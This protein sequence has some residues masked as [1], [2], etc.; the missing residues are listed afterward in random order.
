MKR[1]TVS[2]SLIL[3]LLLSTLPG[4]SLSQ[5]RGPQ[6]AA[7]LQRRAQEQRLKNQEQQKASRKITDEYSDEAYQEA[8]GAT[9]EQWKAIKPRLEKIKRLPSMPGINVSIYSFSG[10]SSFTQTSG[11]GGGGSYS[12]GAGGSGGAGGYSAGSG[13]GGGGMS[14]SSQ[15]SGTAATSGASGSQGGSSTGG[16]GGG[17]AGGYG[18]GSVGGGGGFSGGSP[19]PVKKKVGDVNLG[20]QWRRPSL[21]KGVDKLSESEKTC[22]QLLDALEAKNPNP[23][24]VRRQVEALRKLREQRQAEQRQARQQLREVVTP[25]Q[26]AKLILMGYLD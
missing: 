13:G 15:S 2:L 1:T 21:D 22:E 11:G 26:E 23:D 7:E 18:Q 20:W 12:A 8:L 5:T 25:E 4:R 14:S 10:S 24:Q 3:C 6:S 17:T 16:G 19:G 9:A